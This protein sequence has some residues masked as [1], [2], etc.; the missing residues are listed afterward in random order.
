M[1]DPEPIDVIV[2]AAAQPRT[3]RRAAFLAQDGLAL[4]TAL[5][6]LEQVGLLSRI[7]EEQFF[8]RCLAGLSDPAFGRLR[9]VLRALA[10]EGWLTGAPVDRT[11]AP[12]GWT[13]GGRAVLA[14]HRHYLAVGRFLAPFAD[15]H[16]DGWAGAWKTAAAQLSELLPRVQSRWDTGGLPDARAEIVTGHLD[17]ALLIPAVLAGATESPTP[18]VRALFAAAGTGYDDLP[19]GVGIVGSYLPMLARLGDLL[20]GSAGDPAAYVDRALNVRAGRAANRRYD[21]DLLTVVL[22]VFNRPS[23]A[24]QPRF[25]LDAGCGDG[26]RLLDI[27]EAIRSR[28]ARGGHLGALPVTMVGVDADPGALDAARALLDER[29]VPAVLIERAAGDPAGIAVELARHGLG[30]ADGLHVHAFAGHARKLRHAAVAEPVGVPGAGDGAYV[31]GAGAPVADERVE[32]DLVEHLRRWRPYARRHGLVVLETHT[33]APRVARRFAG[34]RQSVAYDLCHGL[35]RRYPVGHDRWLQC[36]RAAGLESVPYESRRYPSGQPFVAVSLNRL[37][38]VQERT[39]PHVPVNPLAPHEAALPQDDGRGLHELL[40]AGGDT[41]R[42]RPWA[43]DPTGWIVAQALHTVE[44]RVANGSPG[45][46][47]RVLDYGAGTGLGAIELLKA[48]EER[49]TGRLLETSG[50]TLELHLVDIRTAWFD[51]GE[52]LLGRHPWTRFHELR[53]PDGRFRTMTEIMG[54]DRVDVV[55]ASMVF[56]LIPPKSL[57]RV[58]AD[59]ARLI[60]PGGTLL[61]NAPDVGPTGPG[62]FLFHDANRAIRQAVL[63]GPVGEALPDDVRAAVSRVRAAHSA[64][65]DKRAGRRILPTPNSAGVLAGIFDAHFLGNVHQQNFEILPDELLD[66]LLVP[67]NAEEYF[68]ELTLRADREAVVRAYSALVVP[69]LREQDGGTATGLSLKWTFGKH[70]PRDVDSPQMP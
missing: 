56:H 25:V 46:V 38:P 51:Q 42:P 40:F 13:D 44:R 62:A 63:T 9:V 1:P 5:S 11:S 59:L 37:L 34:R 49:G 70:S 4:C 29:G 33:I 3:E 27:H 58:A 31:D 48:I 61:W 30:M 15:A 68:P 67:S 53:G 24:G 60:S 22:D 28:T 8:R 19:P 2:A 69:R 54:D 12:P 6:A 36:A 32:A 17:G 7:G 43:A 55:L 16:R 52:K 35:T 57:A 66:T 50:M 45:Q 26:T 18:E 65:T 41:R 14:Y 10:A 21:E 20:T 39:A 47:I 64:E 23:L